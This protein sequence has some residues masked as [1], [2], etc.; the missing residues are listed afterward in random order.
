MNNAQALKNFQEQPSMGSFMDLLTAK[1]QFPKP[2]YYH[3]PYVGKINPED[4]PS[5]KQVVRAYMKKH[6]L[7]LKDMNEGHEREIAKLYLK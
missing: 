5:Y 3:V 6:S 1:P 4:Y 2:S 7:A